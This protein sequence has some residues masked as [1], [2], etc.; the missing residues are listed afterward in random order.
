MARFRV[1]SVYYKDCFN[2]DES[3]NTAACE[4]LQE[5]GTV[6]GKFKSLYSNRYANIIAHIKSAHD[7][8]AYKQIETSTRGREREIDIVDKEQ[9]INMMKRAFVE[10]FTAKAE[11]QPPRTFF[12]Q[13]F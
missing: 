6:C 9:R 13:P 8:T 11:E 5:D 10:Q 12:S 2:I 3:K 1:P 4:V 7:D